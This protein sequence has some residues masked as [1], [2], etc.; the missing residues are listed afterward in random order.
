VRAN[1]RT[2]E[3]GEKLRFPDMLANRADTY[4]LAEILEG[5]DDVFALSYV[6]N[7]LTCRG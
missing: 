3:T 6:E 7:A 1:A 4:N 5:K 2:S